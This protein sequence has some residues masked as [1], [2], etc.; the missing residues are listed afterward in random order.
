[1]IS[2]G[3]LALDYSRFVGGIAALRTSKIAVIYGV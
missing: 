2:Q 3:F 1:M